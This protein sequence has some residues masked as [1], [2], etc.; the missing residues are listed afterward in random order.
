MN[1]AKLVILIASFAFSTA[2]MAKPSAPKTTAPQVAETP[3]T[4]SSIKPN[5]CP[6]V[7]T[8]AQNDS[9]NN[10]NRAAMR[11]EVSDKLNS[12]HKGLNPGDQKTTF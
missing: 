9:W 5:D 6:F 3:T 7:Q 2:A 10:S 12:R 1:H 8:G 4:S 11:A